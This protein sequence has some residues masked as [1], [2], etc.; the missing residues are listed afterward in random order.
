VYEFDRQ[1]F[2]DGPP[3][4][5]P[6]PGELDAP[7]LGGD[8][9]P[10]VADAFEALLA[11][12]QTPAPPPEPL[13]QEASLSDDVVDR[14]ASRVAERLSEGVF[15]DMVSQIVRSVAERLVREEI[16]RIRAKAEAPES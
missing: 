10:N 8:A 13:P 16:A 12:E 2:G 5:L 15:M 1:W 4:N 3:S 7:D 6:R 11:A 14:I 9:S